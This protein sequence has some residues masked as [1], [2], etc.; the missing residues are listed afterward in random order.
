ML[1]TTMKVIPMT[2][3]ELTVIACRYESCLVVLWF[4]NGVIIRNEE[5]GVFKCP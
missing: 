4:R 2:T 1:L 3:S 5:A